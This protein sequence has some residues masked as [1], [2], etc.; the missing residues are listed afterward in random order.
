[1]LEMAQASL[2]RINTTFANLRFLM[3]NGAEGE[4]SEKEAA[5]VSA[6]EQ[7]KQNFCDAMDDD[8]NSADA[9]AVIFEL[10]RAINTVCA[11]KNVTKTYG[12][13]AFAMLK[14]LC[15]VLAIGQPEEQKDDL[16]QEIEELIAQRQAARKARNFAEADRIRDDLKA[17]GIILEDTPQGVKW[18]R[19]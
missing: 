3:Q 2:A 5:S 1:S 10:V 6:F 9:V 16:E 15:D 4:M 14:E 13:A 19:A 8:L 7:F 17:R 11:E 12:Q 18:S